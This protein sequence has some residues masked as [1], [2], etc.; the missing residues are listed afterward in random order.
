MARGEAMSR[1]R[2][3]LID[4]GWGDSLL[5]ESEDAA[6]QWHY[7]LIDS[8]DSAQTRSSYVFLKRHFERLNF[9]I[10]VSVAPIFTWVLLTHAHA[11]HGQGLKRILRD[12]GTYQFWYP[13]SSSHALF[14]T[15]VV[16]FA[17]RSSLVFHHQSVDDSKLLPNFGDAQMEILW[18]PPNLLARNENDNSVVLKLTLGNASFILTGDAEAHGVWTHI[19]AK[20]PADTQFFKVPHH[21]AYNSTFD[22]AGGTPWLDALPASASLGISSHLLPHPHPDAKVV[23][24]LNRRG[25]AS[26]RTDESYHVTFETDGHQTAVRYSHV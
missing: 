6:G 15:N 12:F 19:A 5:L 3:T 8:N 7:A 20:I 24:E 18:P 1:L 25:T 22:N 10:P 14:F 4:V 21:G 16:R 26:Y 17:S 9:G 2:V 23:E 11:D 13:K